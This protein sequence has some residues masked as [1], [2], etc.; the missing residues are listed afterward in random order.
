MGRYLSRAGLLVLGAALAVAA[1]CARPP[2]PADPV[3]AREALRAALDAWQKGEPAQ[4]LQHGRPAVIVVDYEWR[5]GY[6]LAGYQV[7]GD[8]PFA[9]GLRCRVALAL[10]DPHGRPVRKPAVYTVGTSPVVTV[11]REEEP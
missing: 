11:T 10:T 2:A 5:N 8:E 6:R 9:A 1:G 7:E 3:Q 4:S